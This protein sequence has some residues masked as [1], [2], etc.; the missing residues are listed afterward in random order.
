MVTIAQG[1]H[2]LPKTVMLVGRELTI[3]GKPLKRVLFPSSGITV[4][5]FNHLRL[6]HKKATIN[7]ATITLGLFLKALDAIGLSKLQG[8]IVARGKPPPP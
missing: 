7:P 1:I 5:T 2:R 4:D 6:Q 3:G 8:A